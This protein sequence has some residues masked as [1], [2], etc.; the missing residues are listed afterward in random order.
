[1]APIAQSKMTELSETRIRHLEAIQAVVNRMNSNAFALKALAGTI[2]AAVIA[3]AGAAPDAAPRL[4]WAGIVPAVVF[5][6]MDAQYLRQERLFR[7]LYD[8]VRGGEVEEP[9]SMDFRRYSKEVA[10]VIR[11]AISWSVIWFYLTLVAVL[12]VLARSL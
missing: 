11:I 12:G 3:Y 6:L 8:G 10:H 9:F 4:A 2:T 1:M 5:W 7:K